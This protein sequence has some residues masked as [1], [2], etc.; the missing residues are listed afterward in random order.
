MKKNYNEIRRSRK[1]KV[2]YKSH[3]KQTGGSLYY[4]KEKAN[5]VLKEFDK[6]NWGKVSHAYIV[7]LADDLM[8]FNYPIRSGESPTHDPGDSLLGAKL[9][10]KIDRGDR[11][12]VRRRLLRAAK[13]RPNSPAVKN[14]NDFLESNFPKKSGLEKRAIVTLSILSI[15]ACTLVTIS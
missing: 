10:E 11:V 14:I 4:L 1:W 8:K 5:E 2:E 3:R 15:I 6:N 7:G 12:S 13:E 9:Y